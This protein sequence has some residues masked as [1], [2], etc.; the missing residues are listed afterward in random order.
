MKILHKINL[1]VAVCLLSLVMITVFSSGLKK[2][3]L[4]YHRL[5]E[6]VKQLRIHVLNALVR[7]KNYEKTY[8]G[9]TDVF[10]SLD[11]A[12]ASL[13]GL[14]RELLEDSARVDRIG[15]MLTTF[16]EAFDAMVDAGEG[17][18]ETKDR[19]NDL[20]ESY[21]SKHLR[22]DADIQRRIAESMLYEDEDVGAL[23][24]VCIVSCTPRWAVVAVWWAG[25][26]WD[27]VG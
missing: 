18:I 20:A 22:A 13:S 1:L 19:I 24:D 3:E 11:R 7:E 15:M 8:T 17:L 5:T 10:S 2:Q 12:E 21:G 6:D 25:Y 16:R 27:T 9:D 26:F 4:R 23:Q 14:D